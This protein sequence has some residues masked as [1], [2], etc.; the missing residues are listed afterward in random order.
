MF[1]Y[2]GGDANAA[3]PLMR[4]MGG[5]G[6]LG[7]ASPADLP[8]RGAMMASLGSA[9]APAPGGG[10]WSGEGGDQLGLLM[11]SLGYS[12]MSSPR[13]APLSGL[14]HFMEKGQ[15]QLAKDRESR[16]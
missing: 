5:L 8:A 2:F 3:N 14:P 1:D 9:P 6:G 15:G 12:L 11:R 13:N 4:G 7:G 16:S 10:F